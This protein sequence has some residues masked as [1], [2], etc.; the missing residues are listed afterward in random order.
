MPR[1]KGSKNKKSITPAPNLVEQID[2]QEKVVS[3]LTD[4]LGVINAEIK[5]QQLFAK[6]KKKEIRKAEKVLATLK[7]KQEEAAAIAEAAA[8]KAQIEDVVS[9]LISSG[10]SAEE[11]LNRIK[12]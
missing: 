5:Q 4:D 2:A 8:A 12:D 7:A 11:I 9:K 3:A 10:K 6:A 1:P